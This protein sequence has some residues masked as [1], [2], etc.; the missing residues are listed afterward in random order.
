MINFNREDRKQLITLLR[1]LPELANE[2]SR[3]QILLRGEPGKLLA[4]RLG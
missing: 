3:F 1:D 2:R 4:C